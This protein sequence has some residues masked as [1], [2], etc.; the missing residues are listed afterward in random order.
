MRCPI[1]AAMTVFW[2]STAFLP[3]ASAADLRFP[4][5]PASR[6]WQGPANGFALPFPRGERAQSVW[7][8][9][10]CWRECG[11]RTAWALNA[12][13]ERDAQGQCLNEADASDRAC[14]RQCRTSGGPLLPL[15][16]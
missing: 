16:F 9:G 3:S 2:L 14:Q 6:S 11:A 7:A 4:V 12:C 10:L 8:S 5:Q 15:D 1:V 13:L